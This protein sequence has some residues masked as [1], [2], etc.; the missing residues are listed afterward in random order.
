[1]KPSG[2]TIPIVGRK[3]GGGD[4]F[5]PAT[6]LPETAYFVGGALR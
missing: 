4:G 5:A 1:M 3:F 2:H 6:G